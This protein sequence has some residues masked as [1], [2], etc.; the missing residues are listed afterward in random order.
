MRNPTLIFIGAHPDDETF[1]IGGTL[2][3]YARTGINV[4]YVCA[5]RGEAGTVRPEFMRGFNSIGDMRWA[6]LEFAASVLKL[7]GIFSLGYRDSGMPGSTENH[8][9]DS[10]ASAPI[11]EVARRVVKVIREL[12]PHVVITHDPIGGYRHP[13]HIAVHNAAVKA[14][15]AAGDPSRYP[16]AGPAYQPQKLYFHVMSRRFL[17]IAV[18]LLPIFGRDPRKYGKNGDIDLVSLAEVDFPVHAVIKLTQQDIEIRE[19]ARSCH[20]SQISGPPQSR[21]L[22]I[23]NR[24]MGHSDQYMRA[25]PPVLKRRRESNLF[26]GIL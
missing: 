20:A 26:Q 10:L 9:P 18:R 15:Y 11:E 17:R 22:G 25:F 1:A 4:Y 8:H 12:H 23:I 5:T 16:E 21:L 14:F 13:D 3:L 2:A 6:E 7:T 24:F 19:K